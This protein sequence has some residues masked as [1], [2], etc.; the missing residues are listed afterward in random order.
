MI[1]H[2]NLEE[3]ADPANYDLEEGAAP[4]PNLAF[5]TQLAATTGGPVLDL[6]CGTGLATLPIARLGLATTG[7]DLSAPMV[8]HARRK[9]AAEGLEVTWLTGDVR[10]FALDQRFRLIIMTGNA[11]QAMLTEADQAAL[12]A[13]VAAHLDQGGRFAFETRNPGGHDLTT[14]LVE[15]PWKSYV[16]ISGHTVA[17][18][19]TQV[20]DPEHKLLHWTVYRRW[21][22]AGAPRVQA[23]R[24]ACR[25]TPP[26]ELNAT[27]ARSGLAVEAQYGN[28][29]HSPLTPTSPSIISV[30]RKA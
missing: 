4:G 6:A 11:F 2:N 27:I 17:M 14:Q 3:F 7:L 19:T 12:F 29:D 10:R 15:E 28:W 26:D 30:L 21:E 9:A 20:Y 1:D 22:E 25:F 13:R 23:G 18:S 8:A 5:Y 16:N 24:I